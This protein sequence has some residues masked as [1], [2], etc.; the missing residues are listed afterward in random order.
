MTGFGRGI[1]SI[2]LDGQPLPGAAVPTTLS[3]PHELRIVLDNQAPAA[4][5][6]NQAAHHVSPMTPAVRYAAGRLSWAP[7]EGAQAY[8]VLRN[9]E[10]AG[11]TTEAS[12]A[13]PAGN[14]SY[15]AYQ[16]LAVD[17][18]GFE[19]FASE[20]LAVDAAAFQQQVELATGATKSARPYQG[21]TGRGFIEISLTRN[22][23]L[24]LQLQV[25][26]AGRYALDFRYANGNGP[27]NT[28]NKCAFR[29]L[30]D[31]A[32]RQL[33][34]AVFPQRGVEEWSDWGFSNPI[35]V[36]LKKGPQTLTL[37]YEPANEN[38]NGEVNQAMLNYARLTRVK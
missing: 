38:M 1:S 12:F 20:P 7:V 27:I 16:V 25:P 3:G 15:A 13:V 10:F 35:T 30:R 5:Q 33:G 36:E 4:Q 32:G 9:G 6:V 34:T 26:A 21:A 11:R 29:T 18:Q 31:A 37:A 19:S 2:M 23:K 22:K 8:Q 17:K 28:S 24:T 14:E